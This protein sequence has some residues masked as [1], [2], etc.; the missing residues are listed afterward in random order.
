MMCDNWKSL[1]STLY[2][3]IYVCINI[4]I[5]IYIYIYT[6]LTQVNLTRE[7]IS[8]VVH[9]VIH[10]EE[11]P[12]SW[13]AVSAAIPR[14]LRLSI[15]ATRLPCSSLHAIL[16]W[17]WKPHTNIG[18]GTAMIRG[19]IFTP[20]ISHADCRR[21]YAGD[22]TFACAV[23]SYVK[24]CE[25]LWTRECLPSPYDSPKY[26]SSVTLCLVD[27]RVCSTRKTWL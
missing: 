15:W 23:K 24:G 5:Y 25:C 27:L 17:N 20:I 8:T 6:R 21:R 14:P 11:E 3:Y 10:R 9:V 7:A 26:S 19:T 16:L 22:T 13:D 2:I 18:Y 12:I 1:G 4:Y